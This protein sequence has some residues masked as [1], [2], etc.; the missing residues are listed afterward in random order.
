MGYV[1]VM[2]LYVCVSMDNNENVNQFGSGSIGRENVSGSISE[3]T[4]EL[5][6]RLYDGRDVGV[7]GIDGER[8]RERRKLLLR[9][10][11][12]SIRMRLLRERVEFVYREI[13]KFEGMSEEEIDGMGWD[14]REKYRERGLEL[15]REMD[16]EEEKFRKLDREYR[17]LREEVNES[18]GREIM[19]DIYTGGEMEDD[20]KLDGDIDN[21]FAAADEEKGDKDGEEWKDGNGDSDADWW[22]RIE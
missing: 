5:W 13:E 14:E 19:K 18:F 16:I 17:E 15:M 22:K 11:D 7:N 21:Y 9:A 12:M 8:G 1:G 3:E 20:I 10:L 4:R 6:L 2:V